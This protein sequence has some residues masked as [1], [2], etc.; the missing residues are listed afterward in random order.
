MKIHQI[1]KGIP[2]LIS[3][4]EKDFIKSHGDFVSLYALNEREVWLAQNL[5]RKRVYELTK[6]NTHIV[7][8]NGYESIDPSL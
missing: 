4:E 6:D 2:V 1:L 8:N 7:I 3:N 5:V